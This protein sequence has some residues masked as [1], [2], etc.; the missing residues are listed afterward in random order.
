MKS[1]TCPHSTKFASRPKLRMEH[2]A[3]QARA[4]YRALRGPKMAAACHC[5]DSSFEIQPKAYRSTSGAILVAVA[6]AY[7]NSQLVCDCK[8]ADFDPA[9]DWFL[10]VNGKLRP[11]GRNLVLIDAGDYDNDGVSEV[12]F[13]EMGEGD[14]ED[15]YILL[16]PRD[17]GIYRFVIPNDDAF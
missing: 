2:Q 6:S 12:L 8:G 1:V 9:P 16:Q 11:V 3:A 15:A 14:G 17:G 7:K 4:A 10:A 13:E 5:P